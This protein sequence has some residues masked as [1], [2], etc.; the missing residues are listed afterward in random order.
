MRDV[1]RYRKQETGCLLTMRTTHT[2]VRDES[3][4][5]QNFEDAGPDPPVRDLVREVG[6]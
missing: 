2:Y 5:C 4:G 1:L 3:Y 6:V